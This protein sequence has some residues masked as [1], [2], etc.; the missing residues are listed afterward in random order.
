[1]YGGSD[2]ST[3]S[4]KAKIDTAEIKK[5]LNEG[6]VFTK[7]ISH[8][9]KASLQL[10][11][12]KLFRLFVL[13]LFF[14]FFYQIIEKILFFFDV[15]ELYGNTYLIWFSTIVTLWALLPIKS[16]YLPY[17]SSHNL[18]LLYFKILIWLIIIPFVILFSLF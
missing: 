7:T 17:S 2:Q 4:I 1:M 13:F 15:D 11:N 3:N 9:K 8:T 16:S 14:S 10:L 6:S 18:F 12:T 5:I